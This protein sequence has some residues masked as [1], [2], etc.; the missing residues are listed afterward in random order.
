MGLAR[1]PGAAGWKPVRAGQWLACLVVVTACA[2]SEDLPA[3]TLETDHARVAYR[4]PQDRPCAGDLLQIDAQVEFLED[5]L[6][7]ARDGPVS[8]V[9]L[10]LDEVM[11]L[12]GGA[13]GCYDGYGEQTLSPW[14]AVAHELSHAIKP[15][16][17]FP[18]D[19]WAE[20]SANALAGGLSLIDGSRDLELLDLGSEDL[21]NY[22]R[23]THFQRY[24]IAT[25]G[26]DGYRSLLQGGFDP[27]ASL[28]ISVEELIAQYNRDAP[29][30]YARFSACTDPEILPVREG[31]WE[32][33]S[34]FSC[35]SEHATQYERRDFSGAFS[36]TVGA[37]VHR[38][39]ELGEGTYEFRLDGGLSFTLEGCLLDSLDDEPS[40]VR[41]GGDVFNEVERAIA[42]PFA[43]GETH[44]VRLTE[45]LFRVG[46]SSGTEEEQEL[47][48]TVA[49]VD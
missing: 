49:Q 17:T 31:V 2:P 1:P 12:C 27:S 20:G 16:D 35:E 38:T 43:A 36:S 21:S 3:F 23:T 29:F 11:E 39:I 45:G 8:I 42:T 18:S 13:Q 9:L 24:L 28:G 37:A 44:R 14:N 32:A 6:G 48:L 7:E 19:F 47:R 15:V 25:Y 34:T 22:V 41:L 10:P 26:L 5:V 4:A 46:L 40:D 33:N 30:A